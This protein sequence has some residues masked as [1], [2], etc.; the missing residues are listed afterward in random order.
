MLT[1]TSLR[2]TGPHTPVGCTC[3]RTQVVQQCGPWGGPPLSLQCSGLGNT[4]SYIQHIFCPDDGPNQNPPLPRLP[5]KKGK[6]KKN[7]SLLALQLARGT[8][9]GISVHQQP[10]A[11]MR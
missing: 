11:G 7:P 10:L 8:E 1:K 6:K 9:P 5:P 3:E 4:G 2:Q